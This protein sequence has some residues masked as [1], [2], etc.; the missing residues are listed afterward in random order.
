M[1]GGY[2]EGRKSQLKGNDGRDGHY[3]QLCAL[4]GEMLKSVE[5]KDEQPAQQVDQRVYLSSSRDVS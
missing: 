2:D 4:V 3:V 1:G 5:G